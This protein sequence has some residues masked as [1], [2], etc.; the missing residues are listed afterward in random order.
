MAHWRE[1]P[2]QFDSDGLKS[3]KSAAGIPGLA[4]LVCDSIPAYAWDTSDREPWAPPSTRLVS[5][6]RRALPP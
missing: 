5:A 4:D 2:P 3:R 6:A 1:H